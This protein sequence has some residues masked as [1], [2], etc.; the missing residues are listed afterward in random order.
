V[1]PKLLSSK[2]KENRLIPCDIL[3][4]S[5]EEHLFHADLKKMSEEERKEP[6]KKKYTIR[7]RTADQRFA[8]TDDRIMFQIVCQVEEA[9]S[10]FSA[11]SL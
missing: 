3:R 2:V 4:F 8:G 10:N 9:V 7:V 1:I 11:G 6:E 5:E